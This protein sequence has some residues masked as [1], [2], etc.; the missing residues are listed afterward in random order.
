MLTSSFV[1]LSPEYEEVF[2]RRYNKRPKFIPVGFIPNNTL[3][4]QIINLREESRVWIR[5]PKVKT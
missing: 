3:P 2:F 4:P 5:N 1:L